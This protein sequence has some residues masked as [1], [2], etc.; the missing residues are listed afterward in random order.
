MLCRRCWRRTVERLAG[1]WSR[2]A[3]RR[4]DDGGSSSISLQRLN[5]TPQTWRACRLLA[6]YL[7]RNCLQTIQLKSSTYTKFY[8]LPGIYIVFNSSILKLGTYTQLQHLEGGKVREG[9]MSYSNWQGEMSMRGTVRAGRCPAGEM[10]YTRARHIFLLYS[11]N[12]I[13]PRRLKYGA[14]LF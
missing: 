3:C 6:F 7:W 2:A 5:D 12:R 14:L 10:S 4:I 9:E 13:I 11:C 1:G 8:V